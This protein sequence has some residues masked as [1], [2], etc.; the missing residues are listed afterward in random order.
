MRPPEGP[1]PPEYSRPAVRLPRVTSRRESPPPLC[2]ISSVIVHVASPIPRKQDVPGKALPVPLTAG[3]WKTEDKSVSVTIRGGLH[4]G[5]VLVVVVVFVVS[6]DIVVF[7]F[8]INSFSLCLR[9]RK[10]S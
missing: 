4:Q 8:T 2:T 9:K 3:S 10:R 7:N 5:G 1:T 6:H